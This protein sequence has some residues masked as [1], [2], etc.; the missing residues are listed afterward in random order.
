[1]KIT[2]CFWEKRNLNCRVAEI[3]VEVKDPFS[4]QYFD[5]VSDYDYVVVKVP[6]NKIDFNIGL[7]D[8]GYTMIELQIEMSV[9]IKDFDFNNKLIRFISKDVTF[10]KVMDESELEIIINQITPGMF[11]TDRISLDPVYGSFIG[12]N[13]YIN[14]IRDEFLRNSS[15]FIKMSYKGKHVGFIMFKNGETMISSLGG[16][17][18][19]YQDNGLGLLAPCALPLYVQQNNL[20]IKNIVADISSNNKQVWQLYE[21]FGYK[22]ID[23]HYVY[24]KH[25]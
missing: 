2:D 1:M 13:R 16:V 12:C 22:T 25:Q 14:W 11:S 3:S 8:L 21:H 17:Y 5:K 10:E 15:E 9:K 6:T 19:D 18:S 20:S 23:S 24:V 7:T 4:K